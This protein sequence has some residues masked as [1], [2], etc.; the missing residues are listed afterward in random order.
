[1]QQNVLPG[2][3]IEPFKQNA[4]YSPSPIDRRYIICNETPTNTLTSVR[5]HLGSGVFL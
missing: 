2:H 3:K 5:T 1:M 4:I